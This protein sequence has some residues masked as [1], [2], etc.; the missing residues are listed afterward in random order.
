MVCT[1]YWDVEV[2]K[3]RQVPVVDVTSSGRGLEGVNFY[4]T[5]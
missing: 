4:G 1:M 3:T 5:S 2:A